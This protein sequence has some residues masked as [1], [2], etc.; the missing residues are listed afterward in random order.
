ML[1]PVILALLGAWFALRWYT[2]NMLAEYGPGVEEDGIAIAQSAVRL[3]PRD[4]VPRWK[5]AR[6][7]EKS[8]TPKELDAAV[9]HHAEAV[10]LS[11][12][13]YRLWMDFG[14]ALE[15]SGNGVQAE[16]AFRHAVELA[17]A[18]SYPRWYLGNLLL[19][20]GRTDEAFTELRA[21]AESASQL[22]TQVFSL[23]LQV[24]GQDSVGIKNAIGPSRDLRASLTS[25]LISNRR[26]DD[27]LGLWN[28]F[29]PEEK[30]NQYAVGEDLLKAFAAAKRFHAA[31]ELA[32]ELAPDDNVKPAMNQVFN[33]GFEIGQGASGAGV[34]GWQLVT[35]PQAQTSI[36]SNQY[37]GGR[38]SLRL[39]FKSSSNLTL[40]TVAQLVV[41]EPQTQYKF[42]FYVRTDD[43]RSG[44]TPAFEIV[45]ETDGTLLGASP[46]LSPGTG[47]WLQINIGFGTKAKTEAIRIRINRAS[48]GSD[49]VC[50][51]FG[52]V[53]YDDFNLQRT[54]RIAG[55]K[56]TGEAKAHHAA[57]MG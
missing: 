26:L 8:F 36:D 27:A 1:V 33:G 55:P 30:Q 21:A 28:S 35:V 9:K 25:Y 45:D 43:L 6:L 5:L 47:G 56:P 57:A 12:S 53:W 34:F 51:I 31:L 29:S 54:G 22:R 37:H 44:G 20:T 19:R 40:N 10:S 41:V 17:P 18:Y 49:P 50:P 16:L 24:F 11:P 42:G 2:G 15:L 13:D 14:R 3:A 52:T 7:E 38:R 39:V 32:R 4:P 23:A 46:P 48:C